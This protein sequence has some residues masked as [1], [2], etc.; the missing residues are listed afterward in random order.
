MLA[1]LNR[2]GTKME[3]EGAP[4][5][6][7]VNVV[8]DSDR[9]MIGTLINKS[10]DQVELMNCICQETV[11]GP[12]GQPQCKRSH[13][14]F[15]SIKIASM[16]HF[17]A[18]APPSSDFESLQKDNDSDDAT[19]VEVVFMSERRKSLD[20][21]WEA[22]GSFRRIDLADENWSAANE[23]GSQI[24]IVDQVNQRFIATLVSVEPDQVNVKNCLWTE[25]V[26]GP[27][28]K[29]QFKTNHLPFHS[30]KKTSMKS[31]DITHPP[32]SDLV[33]SEHEG[34]CCDYV[35]DKFVMR[36][37]RRQGWKVPQ[38]D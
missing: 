7:F 22:K 34:C 38:P 13:T 15:C 2:H 23:C 21:D 30:F 6:S 8:D 32:S 3:I 26:P 17:S 12:E 33:A 29:A 20:M 5:G 24:G 37:G 18:L 36:S 9:R 1:D 10:R 25:T 35:I 28:G 31:L 11:P 27:N 19:V 4:C 14:P 16:T